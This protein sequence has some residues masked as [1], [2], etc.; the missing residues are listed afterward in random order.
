MN[1]VDYAHLLHFIILLL[2]WAIWLEVFKQFK[3]QRPDL[4]DW[5]IRT[6]KPILIFTVFVKVSTSFLNDGLVIFL[7][8]PYFMMHFMF[9]YWFLKQLKNLDK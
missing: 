6:V 4:V 3:T 1:T 2:E 7:L 8:T 5:R 9:V